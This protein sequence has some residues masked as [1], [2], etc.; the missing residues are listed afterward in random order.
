MEIIIRHCEK[1]DIKSIQALY[2][3]T[4]NFPST[5]DLPYSCSDKWLKQFEERPA[6]FY[7]LVAEIDGQIVGEI[8]MQNYDSPRRKHA[9]TLG[10]AVSEQFQGKGIGGKLLKALIEL[11]NN[12][13]NIQRL[14][15]EVFTDN[16]GAIALYKKHGFVIE[17]TAKAFAFRNGGFVDA[18]LMANTVT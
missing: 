9:A 8:A 5:T 18:H 17:G 6:S 16:L 15:L 14:E 13:L 3:Q 7:S 11:A 12:W 10:M 4:S 1:A 2:E